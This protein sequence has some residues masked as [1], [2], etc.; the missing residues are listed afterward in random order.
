MKG[1]GIALAAFFMTS[2]FTLSSQ[3]LPIKHGLIAFW[4]FSEEM[5]EPRKS[6]TN[7]KNKSYYLLEGNGGIPK[8]NEDPINGTSAAIQ[9]G[10]WFFIP[11]DSLGEL[12]IFGKDAQV[13]V[14]AWVKKESPK[15]WQAIAGVWDESRSKRQFYMFLNAHSK[16]HYNEMVRYPAQGLLHGHISATG[17]KSP[18]REAWISYSSSGEPVPD[19]QWNCIAITYD[20][21]HIKSYIN[22]KL[23]A[24]EFSNPFPY[25]HGIFD[26]GE[27]GAD[28][29][30]GANSV[31]G[32]M[33]N[34]FIG[35]ISGLAVFDTALSNKDIT[36]LN[37]FGISVKAEDEDF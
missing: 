24:A 6:M 10:S 5:G 34:Q 22:G 28:F 33:T 9:D 26:G 25:N 1:L 7:S 14:V 11:R 8:V 19:N 18:D 30:V 27:D 21:K 17:G 12:N 2:C 4:D 32:K 36:Y 3:T 37:K 31:S 35:K 29:T 23:S 15:S 13:T 20:G 16:T